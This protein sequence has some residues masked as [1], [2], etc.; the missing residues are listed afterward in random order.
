MINIRQNMKTIPALL[1]LL[2]CFLC[3]IIYREKHTGIYSCLV[4]YNNIPPEINADWNKE[5]WEMT[6]PLFPSSLA[7][8]GSVRLSA[9]RIPPA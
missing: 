6:I 7:H 2:F 1:V 9:A 4:Q 5:M 3:E 8:M